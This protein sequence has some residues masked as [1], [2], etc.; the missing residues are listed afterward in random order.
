[1]KTSCKAALDQLQSSIW[2]RV[3]DALNNL[4]TT[5]RCQSKR[6]EAAW[7]YYEGL[8]EAFGQEWP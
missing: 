7:D 5:K 4:R 6:S 3:N 1:M 2:Q 8:G